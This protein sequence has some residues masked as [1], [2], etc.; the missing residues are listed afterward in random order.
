[1]LTTV[2]N[3]FD[4]F[5]QFDEWFNWDAQAGYYTC[6]LL[7]RFTHTSRDLSE[8]DQLLAIESAIDDILELNVD[9]VY[10]RVTK[11]E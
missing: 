6:G 3:P 1:M 9:G 2:D 8:E 7:A 4:P 5:T 11:Q 10:R